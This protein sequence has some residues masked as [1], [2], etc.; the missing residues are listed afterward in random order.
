MSTPSGT[1]SS[2]GIGPTFPN[3]RQVWSF[4]TECSLLLV[5]GTVLALIWANTFPGNHDSLRDLA[6]IGDFVIGALHE[7]EGKAHRTL[8]LHFLAMA[9]KEAWRAST[10]RTASCVG[11]MG[12]VRLRRDVAEG[13]NV[14]RRLHLPGSPRLDFPG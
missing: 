5:A 8:T 9:G 1:S 2:G 13:R 3:G 4:V 7:A 12:R 11:A 6:L 10:S 14:F